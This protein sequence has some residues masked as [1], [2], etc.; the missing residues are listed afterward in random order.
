MPASLERKRTMAS[1]A[2][3]STGGA[4]T[5]SLQASPYCPVNPVLRARVQTL[6]VSLAFISFHN[7]AP[8]NMRAQV[9]H[10]GRH[11]PGNHFKGDRV[12]QPVVAR[13]IRILRC[14]RNRVLLRGEPAVELE[15]DVQFLAG[16][17][18][19]E[20]HLLNTSIGAIDFHADSIA[21]EDAHHRLDTPQVE[22]GANPNRHP[23]A[24]GNDSAG[25]SALIQQRRVQDFA[26]TIPVPV[27][28][29][30]M[31]PPIE[32]FISLLPL[33]DDSDVL[34]DHMLR[35]SL[36]LYPPVQEENGAIRKLFHQTEIVRHEKHGGFLLAQI[37]K[38]PDAAV[39]EDGVSHREGLVD[40]QN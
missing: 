22:C 35:L 39:R 6:S 18:R 15:V 34:V 26:R 36:S 40:D 3:P 4:H 19:T 8:F 32:L 30:G 11:A 20:V 23:F 38:L 16:F 7:F 5:C 21:N 27:R 17:E 24:T 37:L 13:S 25:S 2:L 31:K 1:F 28:R 12:V 10:S 9:R 33:E 14:D 29:H